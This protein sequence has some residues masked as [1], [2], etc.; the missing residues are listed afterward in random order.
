MSII[1]NVVDVE[2]GSDAWKLERCGKVTASRIADMMAK[3]KSGWGASRANYRAE[4]VIEKLTRQPAEKFTN[5][6][7]AWGTETEPQ[8]RIMYE[9]MHDVEVRQ[10]GMVRHATIANTLASPDGLVGDE[11]LIEIKCPQSNTHIE[12]LLSGVVP[13]KYLYQIAWQMACCGPHIAWADFVS[14]DPRMPAGMQLFVQRIERD[15][16]LIKDLEREVPLFLAEVDD[17]VAQLVRR[18][19]APQLEEAA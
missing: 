11:G 4:L 17:T 16:A 5:A 18:Y 12:T 6:A 1:M 14:Y 3:T 7:M 15:T 10:V 19:G 9:L 8:A 13:Q 2:Q